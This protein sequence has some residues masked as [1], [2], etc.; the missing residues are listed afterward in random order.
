MRILILTRYTR[1]GASSRM[2]FFQFVPKFEEAGISCD[3]HALL[4]D[5]YLEELYGPGPVSKINLL[6]C[7]LGMFRRLLTAGR[8]GLVLIE[9]E[10]FPFFPPLAEWWLSF[11]KI[12]YITD[13]DDAIFHNY[14]LHPRF[15]VRFLLGKKI[16]FIMR[17]SAS[18]ICGNGYL[19]AYGRR[20]GAASVKV[21]PTVIDP[22]RYR[23]RGAGGDNPPIIGWI[24]SP[25]SLKYVQRL[26]PVL[27]RLAA[28]HAVELHLVGAGKGIGLER[29]KVLPW[30][31][32][33]EAG[34][35]AAFDI[36][37]MPLE[38]S[39]WE[40]GKCGYKLIQYMGCSLPVIGSP[41]GVNESIILEGINGFK[42]S[43]DDGWE[44]ALECLL[45][46]GALRR[47][48]GARGR[49]IVLD[50][51]SLNHASAMWIEELNRIYHTN[52]K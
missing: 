19:E 52:R 43:D 21:I 6:K 17:R 9:K 33:A 49:E 30:S 29:E 27:E 8:Y 2:R 28:R 45:G 26:K 7:Y 35:I 36:G 37:I 3:V 15:V 5:R 4:N 22:Y 51:Y 12:P 48:M 50:A 46:D 24:G 16:A 34:L 41:V 10:I 47:E 32:A 11:R 42:P 1:L 31:E 23:A 38:D 14:D 18:V 40:K 20:A 25:S 39:P 44:R 13:Y